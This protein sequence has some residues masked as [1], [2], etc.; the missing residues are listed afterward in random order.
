MKSCFLCTAQ[1]DDSLQHYSL[2]RKMDEHPLQ[3]LAEKLRDA[4]D[5][6]KVRLILFPM[7]PAGSKHSSYPICPRRWMTSWARSWKTGCM[8]HGQFT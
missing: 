3:K 7:T 8:H 1:T 6:D 5:K 2:E 4:L